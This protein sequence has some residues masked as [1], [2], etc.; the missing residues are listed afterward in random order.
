M[1]KVCAIPF[2]VVIAAVCISLLCAPRF[3]LADGYD[4]K[5]QGGGQP[6]GR[7]GAVN[8]EM[9]VLGGKITGSVATVRGTPQISGTVSPDGQFSAEAV[10][11]ITMKGKFSGDSVD[12]TVHTIACDVHATG[13]KAP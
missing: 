6:V 5:W 10:S 9:S 3:A 7:C 13:K 1:K 4:G 11:G 2:S 8:F 12:A